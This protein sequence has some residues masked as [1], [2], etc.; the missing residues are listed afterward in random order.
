MTGRRLSHSCALRLCVLM[1]SLNYI[2]TSLA[3]TLPVGSPTELASQGDANLPTYSVQ[4]NRRT[5][6]Q[7]VS[8]A[9][10]QPI[11]EQQPPLNPMISPDLGSQSSRPQPSS[12][13]YR[14]RVR[15]RIGPI[16]DLVVPDNVSDDSTT[17]LGIGIEYGLRLFARPAMN[18]WI[19]FPFWAQ[20]NTSSGY[21]NTSYASMVGFSFEM[22]IIHHLWAYGYLT[23]GLG[24]GFAHT[25]SPDAFWS[26]TGIVSQM[27]AGLKVRTR[28]YDIGFEPLTISIFSPFGP[29]T[30]GAVTS[31]GMLMVPS[32]NF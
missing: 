19:N 15:L 25:T 18:L 16:W 13:E 32:V 7:P 24:T 5:Q 21:S 11:S 22:E 28:R 6:G 27:A 4:S 2:G 26:Q 31:W 12:V 14:Q 30:I 29:N 8:G 9:E 17:K 10:Q 23:A 3:Q 1:L 20:V